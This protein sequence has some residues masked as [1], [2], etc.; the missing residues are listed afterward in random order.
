MGKERNP[1]HMP[2]GSP[3]GGQF[4]SGQ[5][6]KI[7]NAAREAAGL[8]QKKWNGVEGF[9]GTTLDNAKKIYNE[10]ILINKNRDRFGRE[11]ATYFFSNEDEVFATMDA[12][13]DPESVYIRFRIPS[14]VKSKVFFDTEG[15]KT[16]KDFNQW[17]IN[18]DVKP[19]WITGFFVRGK[20]Y[21]MDDFHEK[22]M[23]GA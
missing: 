17:G 12:E 6:N 1:Y 8:P 9:H 18:S 19:E 15:F 3:E 14:E 7:E 22:F 5:L 23:R 21:S 4:T 13:D 2:A 10:G 20:F 16:Y 11:P